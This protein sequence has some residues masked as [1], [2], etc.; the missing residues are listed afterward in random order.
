MDSF[1][2]RLAFGCNSWRILGINHR[3][4]KITR[5]SVDSLNCN[6]CQI[7][8]WGIITD[9]LIAINF[10][11]N[12]FCEI[13]TVCFCPSSFCWHT[14]IIQRCSL[15]FS[16]VIRCCCV[17]NWISYCHKCNWICRISFCYFFTILV[18]ILNGFTNCF[19]CLCV[20]WCINHREVKITRIS[21]DSLNC[22]ACQIRVWGIIT[23]YLIA[24]NFWIN[25]FCE[26]GTVCFCP[27]SFCWHT[28]IIQRCSLCFSWVIRCCCVI[29]WISYCHK[30]NWICRISF[31]YFFT[32]LVNILNG[33]T[34]CFAC[35]CVRWCIDINNRPIIFSF[36]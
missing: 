32:I 5:I 25:Y 35:L 3:E 23:D 36:C 16:W 7:R 27:S 12:Y 29:N 9:Y 13:G 2:N 6:V 34:N 19:A 10:W 30:C 31:C 24:I 33:F 20:R 15:C 11:I 1:I 18:N 17:I 28:I 8:V 26:I 21:V 4:V 14:I 22:N